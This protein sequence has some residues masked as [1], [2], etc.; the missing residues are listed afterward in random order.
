MSLSRT[1]KTVCTEL[2]PKVCDLLEAWFDVNHKIISRNTGLN[3]VSAG[4]VSS[5]DYFS[6]AYEVCIV[7]HRTEELRISFK[8]AEPMH[9]DNIKLYIERRLKVVERSTPGGGMKNEE[10]TKELQSKVEK[11]TESM[12]N[13]QRMLIG[14]SSRGAPSAPPRD[15]P[16]IVD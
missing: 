12:E 7:T 11:L 13:I 9:A 10:D 1:E 14:L 4:R 5:T 3:K 8:T 6:S 15:Y 2:G 16:R